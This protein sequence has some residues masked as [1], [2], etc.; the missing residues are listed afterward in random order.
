MTPGQYVWNREAALPGGRTVP[1]TNNAAAAMLAATALATMICQA[2]IDA[3]APEETDSFALPYVACFYHQ[4]CATSAFCVRCR[5]RGP[6]RSEI[7]CGREFSP[8]G[9][10]TCR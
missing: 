1:G 9:A 8:S 6:R 3:L 5:Y 4:H 2:C 10:G 7:P